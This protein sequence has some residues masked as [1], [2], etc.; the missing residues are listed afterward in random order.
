LIED[1]T[2]KLVVLSVIFLL[3]LAGSIFLLVKMLALQLID[4]KDSRQSGSNRIGLIGKTALIVITIAIGVFVGLFMVR[5]LWFPDFPLPTSL[6]IAGI[7]LVVPYLGC[8]GA[9]FGLNPAIE[10]GSSAS[11]IA[12]ALLTA[13][14]YKK[15]GVAEE[16][17]QNNTTQDWRA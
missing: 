14:S 2:T 17:E 12:K 8:L 4:W 10:F 3:P 15:N 9:I 7:V 11:K 13:K 16:S 5:F 1:K 6:K